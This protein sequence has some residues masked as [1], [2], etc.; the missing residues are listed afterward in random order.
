MRRI[1]YFLL[2]ALL[3]VPG[4]VSA[5][6]VDE[7]KKVFSVDVPDSW[8]F[9]A[10]EGAWSNK[11]NTGALVL[12]SVEVPITLDL[13]AANAAK[14]NPKTTISKDTLGGIAAKRLEF[15][16]ADGYKTYL[17]IAKKGKQGAI[18]TLVHNDKCPDNIPNIKKALLSTYKWK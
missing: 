6:V 11:D 10:K 12:S 2:L 16:T 9:N 7:T 13:W 3:V 14:Q 15:T 18:V 17:W 8:T 4:L 1:I 5:K